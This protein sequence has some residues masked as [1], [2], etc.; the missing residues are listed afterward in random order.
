MIISIV[1]IFFIQ[2]VNKR[3]TSN[4]E[5]V[6]PKYTITDLVQN[7]EDVQE[8]LDGYEELEPED[9]EKLP[10]NTH[11]RYIM[12]DQKNNKELFRFGGI[13]VSVTKKNVTIIV[14]NGLKTI[15]NRHRYN[16]EGQ[17][18]YSTRFF[19][20]PQKEKKEIFELKKENRLL[21]EY[22]KKQDE[23]IKR[24]KKELKKV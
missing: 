9:I 19:V 10:F 8:L 14:N 24:L 3:M 20:K 21:M 15:V 6:R 18:I 11:V 1:Y 2:E 7:P 5:Y 22:I 4:E 12:L 17:I 23:V 13:M 16:S